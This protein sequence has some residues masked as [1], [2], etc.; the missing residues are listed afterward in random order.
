MAAFDEDKLLW[1]NGKM[2]AWREAKIHVMSHVVHYGSSIFEGIRCYNTPA[3]PKILRLEDHLRRMVASCRVYRMEMPF[4]VEQIAAACKAVI[5][6][7]DLREAYIRPI[8]FRGY[9]SLGINP[10]NCPVDVAV[11][12][13]PWGTYLG[14]KA[15]EEGVDAC[16]SSWQKFRENTLP[17]MAKAG[18]QYLNAQL[19]KMEARANGFAE[20]ILLDTNGFISEG[21]GENLFLVAEGKVITSPISAA[22]LPGI[23]RDMTVTLLK[24]EGIEVVETFMPREMLYMADEI[25]FT[26]TAAEITPVRS[27]D[28]I[29]VG[30]GKRGR[31][32]QLVQKRFFEI[33]RGEVE[34]RHHWLTSV[35]E[36][37]S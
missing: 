7:N 9:Y 37:A 6:E 34:D 29:K 26:G 10:A 2:I 32:C 13:W 22:I 15:L 21:S 33:V 27:V 11:G 16:V 12:A 8:A 24:E 30:D 17:A 23:T 28:H 31:I 1:F 3:G 20:G 4:T 19:V 36:E 25:F 18:G 5:R 35:S 14:E